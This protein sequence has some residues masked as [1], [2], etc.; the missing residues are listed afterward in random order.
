M[1]VYK[2]FKR[3]ISE[4]EWG[5]NEGNRTKNADFS[6]TKCKAGV[7]PLVGQNPYKNVTQTL[8]VSSLPSP[9]LKIQTNCLKFQGKKIVSV[10]LGPVH[11]WVVYPGKEKYKI[12]QNITVL[13]LKDIPTQWIYDS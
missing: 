8:S 3:I 10:D 1:I 4:R 11:I 6:F 7:Q 12:A 2:G 5:C 13:P 9:S